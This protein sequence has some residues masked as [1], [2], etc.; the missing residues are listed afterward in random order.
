MNRVTSVGIRLNPNVDAKTLSKISTGKLDSKFGLLSGNFLRFCKNSKNLK[1]L[2]L[3][4]LV[5]I[6]VVKLH[7]LHHTKEL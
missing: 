5:F 6:L 7:L 4:Q 1:I 3:V 2:K